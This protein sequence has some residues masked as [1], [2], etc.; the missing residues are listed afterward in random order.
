MIHEPNYIF[1]TFLSRHNIHLGLIRMLSD[2]P[3]STCV[4]VDCGAT[5]IHPN[6]CGLIR[7][8][9]HPNKALGVTTV[10]APM[11]DL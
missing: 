11:Y 6:T 9:Q 1:P 7:I 3:Q 8:R 4:E 5:L 10:N 2:S